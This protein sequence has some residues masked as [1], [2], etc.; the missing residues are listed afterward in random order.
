MRP[1]ILDNGIYYVYSSSSKIS[2][3]EFWTKIRFLGVSFTYENSR[4]CYVIGKTSCYVIF[5]IAIY[6]VIHSI[7]LDSCHF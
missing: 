3:P 4:F 6:I 1:K 2:N 5:Y 7:K